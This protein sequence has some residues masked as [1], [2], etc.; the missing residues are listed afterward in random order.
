M[1]I[2]T[3][4]AIESTSADNK[5]VSGVTSSV[6]TVNEMEM[7]CIDIT[8]PQA[9]ATLH[10]PMGRYITAEGID[11][12]QDFRNVRSSIEAL[13][14]VIREMIPSKGLVLAVGLGNRDITADALGPKSVTHILATRH[15]QGT[16]AAETGL[17]RLRPT[18]VTAA[19]VL[20]QTGLEAAETVKGLVD[21]LHPCALIVID[22]LAA[23]SWERLGTTVQIGNAG[24]APGSGV[25][26]HR[27]PLNRETLGLPVIAV[28]VPTV[29]EAA[30]LA[31]D[32]LGDGA[33]QEQ[34]NRLQKNPMTVTPKNIDLLTDR[35]A[36]L[37]GMAI[38]CALQ[39]AYDF[40]T[41]A[42]LV[43]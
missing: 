8:T 43:S 38:N 41:L 27:Q 36:K 25:G 24:I 2:R 35:A 17:H 12:T 19:G 32:L 4:L 23:R 29:V 26:N 11:L 5:P 33:D 40:D 3:D 28:G 42:A 6:Y 13:G 31:A 14:A 34:I 21:I 39:P 22:A 37:V 20:G 30:T 16:L 7:H 15:I 1:D 10:K 18:A 9:A